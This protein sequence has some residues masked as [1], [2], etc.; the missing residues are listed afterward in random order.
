MHISYL[1]VLAGLQCR[2]G[3]LKGRL[4]LLLACLP[5]LLA[6]TDDGGVVGREEG[7]ASVLDGLGGLGIVQ[8]LIGKGRREGGREGGSVDEVD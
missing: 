3:F 4:L 7:T 8:V 5:S 6:S 1:V 2:L